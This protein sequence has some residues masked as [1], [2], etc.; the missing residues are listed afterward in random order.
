VPVSFVFSAEGPL[1]FEWAD[2]S[3]GLEEAEISD[4]C[5]VIRR[6]NERVHSHHWPLG[7]S[8]NFRFKA[9]FSDRKI[10][11]VEFP[12][13]DYDDDVPALVV[14]IERYQGTPL[15][16][17]EAQVAWHAHSDFAYGLDEDGVRLLREMRKLVATAAST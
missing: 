16:L 3:T 7:M 15:A 6:L 2:E 13:D 1:A 11:T 9:L 14:P 12:I 8:L 4:V 5:E 17:G 10:A